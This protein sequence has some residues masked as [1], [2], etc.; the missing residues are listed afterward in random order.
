VL[1]LLFSAKILSIPVDGNA[2][3]FGWQFPQLGFQH[4]HATPANTDEC[5]I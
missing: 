1:E 3:R 5:D 4:V 2:Q